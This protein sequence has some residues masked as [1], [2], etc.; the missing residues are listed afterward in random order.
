MKTRDAQTIRDLRHDVVKIVHD[1]LNSMEHG[2]PVTKTGALFAAHGGE[3]RYLRRATEAL[4][5]LVEIAE[6]VK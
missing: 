2:R 4:E 1:A 5:L 3:Q 6:G